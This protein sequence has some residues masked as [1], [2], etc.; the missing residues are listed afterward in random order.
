MVESNQIK[1]EQEVNEKHKPKVPRPLSNVAT[2]LQISIPEPMQA[3]PMHLSY[4][5]SLVIESGY[6]QLRD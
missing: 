4:G 3:L 6:T 5:D 2:Q 1:L